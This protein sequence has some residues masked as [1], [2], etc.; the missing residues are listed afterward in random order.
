[1]KI[2]AN[3]IQIEVEDSAPGASH[4]RAGVVERLLPLLTAHMQAT[5]T[6]KST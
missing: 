5:H 3:S 2:T 1:M 4:L 6:L